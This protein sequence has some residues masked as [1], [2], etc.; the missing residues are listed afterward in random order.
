MAKLKPCPFCGGENIDF[1]MKTTNS[2]Y[3]ATMYCRKCHCYGAR[4]LVHPT[5][6]TWDG[7]RR[8][9]SYKGKAIEAWNRRADDKNLFDAVSNIDWGAECE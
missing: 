4:V 1:S 2:G 8:N 9:A 5:E 6:R 7:I 3:H